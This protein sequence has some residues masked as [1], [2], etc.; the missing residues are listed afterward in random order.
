MIIFKMQTLDIHI[1]NIPDMIKQTPDAWK[2]SVNIVFF[3]G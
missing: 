1:V 3:L 2:E